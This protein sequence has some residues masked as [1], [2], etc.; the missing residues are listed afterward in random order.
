MTGSPR[1]QRL[2]ERLI[3]HARPGHRTAR[4]HPAGIPRWTW[5]YTAVTCIATFFGARLTS[6]LS[7]AGTILIS[8]A[9]ASVIAISFVLW[10]RISADKINTSDQNRSRKEATKNTAW[11]SSQ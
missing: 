1:A 5:A 2:A 10:I 6:D 11:V 8:T 7:F 3:R 4:A 9:I